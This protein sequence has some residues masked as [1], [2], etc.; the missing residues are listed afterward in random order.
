MK[1]RRSTP[2][3]V[4]LASLC[5]GQA[6]SLRFSAEDIARK[7][8]RAK[9]SFP[10]LGLILAA[11]GLLCQAVTQAQTPATNVVLVPVGSV[12][13]YL[14]NGSDQG[15]AWAQPSFDDSAWLS[16]PAQL[17]YGDGDEATQV[18]FG[19]DPGFKYV[20]TY[21]RHE[22][23]LGDPAPFTGLTV[24]LLRD[25]GGVVYLNGVEVFRSNMPG[26]L[27]DYLTFAA[28]T[29]P[30]TDESRFFASGVDHDL[31]VSG[32][33]VLAVEIHQANRT[34]SDISFD[35]EL[36]ATIPTGPP[37]IVTQPSS[38]EVFVGD[39][40]TFAVTVT[41]DAPLSYQWDLD[42]TDIP[43]AT[44]STLTLTAVTSDAVGTYRV[45]VTNALGSVTSAK[46]DLIV[47]ELTADTF[48]ITGL[49]SKGASAIDA[50]SHTGTPDRGGIAASFNELFV[51]NSAAFGTTYFNLDD[52]SFVN[53]LQGG[54]DS[55]L[56]D[57]KTGRVYV[58]GNG[59]TPLSRNGGTATVLL[60]LDG[61]TGVTNGNRVTLSSPIILPRIIQGVG[62]FSG[63]GRI[64]LHNGTNVFD[65]MLP[66]GQVTDLGAMTMPLHRFSIS[67]ESWAFWGVAEFFGGATWLVYVRDPQ[68]IVRT[69]VPDGF[70]ETVTNFANLGNMFSFTVSLLQD[71]WYFEHDGVS[72]FGTGA[73]TVGYADATFAYLQEPQAPQIVRQPQ[74]LAVPA[75]NTA[76]FSVKV[77]GSSPLSYQWQF[78]GTNI[79]GATGARLTLAVVT[80]NQ[81]GS[82]RVAVSN[83]L[84]SVTSSN[85]TLEVTP[86][87]PCEFSPTLRASVTFQDMLD[88]TTMTIAFDGTNYWS[89]S[90]GGSFG[91]R[92][93]RY[94]SA[95]SLLGT[96]SPGLDLRSI[97]TDA[98][99]TLFA[100]AYAD[101]RIFRQSSPGNFVPVVTLNGGLLDDQSDVV[102][103][104]DGTEFVAMAGG[105]VSRWNR[106]GVFLGS[107]TLSGFGQQGNEAA[108]PQGRGIAIADNS[109][110][111]YSGSGVLSVWDLTGHRTHQ[112]T[113]QSAGTS[114][115]SDY[116]FSFCNGRVFVV[117]Y[118][119]STWRGYDLCINTPPTI[120][121]QPENQAVLA[122]FDV[123]LS[124][125]VSGRSPLLYQWLF[126]GEPIPGA[127]NAALVLN[128]VTTN[129]AG[130]YSFVV[131]N[132][133]GW[134]ASSNALLTVIVSSA[135]TFRIVSLSTNGA[136]VVDANPL[137]GDDRGGIA[138]SSQQVFYSGD[139]STVRFDVADMSGATALGRVYDGLVSELGTETVYSLANGTNL[140]F[141]GSG[142]VNALVELD[143]LTG[144]PTTR[145]IPLSRSIDLQNRSS[146]VG[147]FAGLGRIVLH[148]SARV[149]D[150][151]LPSGIVVDLG[152]MPV[153]NHQYSENWAYWGVAEYTNGSIWLVYVRDSQTIVRTRV[154]DGLTSTVATFNFLSDMASIT[155]SLSL[156]RWY[157]HH[158]GGSQFG[159]FDEAFGFADATLV[160]S[161]PPSAP[162]IIRQPTDQTVATR[163][164]VELKVG[165]RGTALQYQWRFGDTNLLNATNATLRLVNVTTNQSGIYSVVV[166]N[167]LGSV[168]SSNA[169][170]TVVPLVG[171]TF[172]ITALTTN[173]V[174]VMDDYAVAGDDRGGIAVSSQEVF[175]SGDFSTARFD[176]ADLSGGVA[177]GRTYD[178]L[179]SELGSEKVYS[180]GDGTNLISS[181]GGLVAELVELDDVTGEPTGNAIALSHPI[182][183]RNRYGQVGIFAG[184]GRIV[185][186]DGSHA[187]QIA[188][189]SGVVLDLGPMAAFPHQY[190]E[191][192]AYWGVAE[193]VTGSIW[194]VYVRDYQTIVRTRVPDGFTGNFTAFNNLGDMSSITVS[195]PFNR[196]YFHHQYQSQFSTLYGTIGFA[197]AVFAS[198]APPIAPSI[199]RQPQDLTLAARST[200]EFKVVIRGTGLRYQWRFDGVPIP[201]GI[202]STL[203]LPN[204]T[205]NQSGFYSVVVSNTLGVVISSNA[206]LTVVPLEGDTF[207]IASLS[208]NNAVVVDDS[209]LVGYDRG[210]IAASAEQVFFSGGSATAKFDLTDLSG[211]TTLG[212]IYD[213]MVSELGSERLY[214]LGNGTNLI[215]NPGGTVTTLLELDGLS[216]RLTGS[217]ISLSR[218]IEL[219]NRG[220]QV[221]IF[222]G[223]GRIVVHDGGRAW[224]IAVPSGQVLDLGPMSAPIHQYS[225][226]WAY[227]GVAEFTNSALWLVYVRDSQSIVRTRV[228]DGLT[229]PVRTFDSLSDMACITVSL[230]FN[231]WY[232][233]HQYQSQF[234]SFYLTMGFADATFVS[235]LPPLA[236]EIVR[237]PLNE[238][239]AAGATVDFKVVAR[240][241]G[242]RYQWL[243]EG[244]ALPG[245]TNSTLTLRNVTANQAGN[246]SVVVSNLLAS[247]TSANAALSVVTV[248]GNTFQITRLSTNGV[249]TVEQGYLTGDDRGGL[250]AS[251]QELFYSGDLSSARFDLADL[252]GASALGRIHD[253]L[254]SD[255]GSQ[256]IYELGNGTNLIDYRGGTVTT[257][258]ELDEVTGEPTGSGVLLSRPI[259]LHPVPAQIGIFCGVGRIVLHDGTRVWSIELPSGLV[260]NLGTMPPPANHQYSENWAYWGI[261]EFFNGA[262]HLVYV[263]DS[264]VIARTRV[265]DGLTTSLATFEYLGDMASITV[266]LP[267]NR[268][269]FHSQYPPS[270]VQFYE[271]V[272]YADAA[273]AVNL[274][275][276][277]PTIVKQPEDQMVASSG[278]V[279]FKAWAKGTR[280]LQYQWFLD[281]SPLVGV[282][283]AT[284]SLTGVNSNRA[285]H[286]TFVVTNVYGAATSAP[287]LLRVVPPVT[288]AVFDDPNFVNTTS[289]DMY[290]TSDNLQAS[291]RRLGHTVTTFTSIATAANTQSVLLFPSFPYGDLVA[292]L[293]DTTRAALQNFVATGGLLIISSGDP[294]RTTS[295]LNTVF[296][297]TIQGAYPYQ[298]ASARTPLAAGTAFGD[299]PPLLPLNYNASELLASTLPPG[300]RSLY[301][302][303]DPYATTRTR[304]ALIRHGNGKIVFL[305][306]DWTDAFP[307]WRLDNGWLK[308]LASAVEESRPSEAEAPTI[309]SQPASQTLLE[310]L[311]LTF[312]V[313][314][315]GYPL[316]YQ[317][318]FNGTPLAGETNWFLT[319]RPARVDQTGNYA[320]VISNALGVVTS[321]VAVAT[322]R[323]TRG[324][325]A[326]FTDGNPSVTDPEAPILQAGFTP[327]RI[328]DI[329]QFDFARAQLLMLNEAIDYV[330]TVELRR[331]LPELRDWV[332]NGG[333]LIVHDRSVSMGIPQ[334]NA[335]LLGLTRTLLQKEYG[336]DIN[337]IPPG[338]TLVTRGPHGMIG[339]GSLD[340]AGSSY[341]GFA[342]RDTIP[343]GALPILRT[344]LSATQVVAFAYGLGSGS[345]YY[346]ALP[347]DYLLMRGDLL[348][349][350]FRRTYA[351]NVIEFVDAYAGSGQPII[352]DEPQS[353]SRF[354]GSRVVFR[355][356][357][358]G[359]APLRYQW[360]FNGEAITDATN[361]ALV[362]P[363]AT[364]NNIGT[365]T[366]HIA[367]AFGSVTSRPATLI[368]IEAST[369]KI[370]S[371][372]ANGSRVIDHDALTGDDRGSIAVSSNQVF[373]TGDY[374]TARFSAADLTAATGLGRQYDAMVSNL[375][376]ERVYSLADGTNVNPGGGVV[377]ALIEING[378]TGDLTTNRIELSEP[379]VVPYGTGIFAGYDCIALHNGSSVYR[380]EIPS[381]TVINLG[382]MIMPN[383]YGCDN[384]AYWGVT[385]FFNGDVYLVYIQDS[386][387]IA[388]VR[389]PDGETSVVARF[390]YLS[391]MC[392][393][394]MSLSRNRWYFHHEGSSQFGGNSETLGY[395]N[396]AWDHPP[397]IAN[398]TNTVMN[399]DAVIGPINFSI[400]DAETSFSNLVVTARSSN[401][402]LLPDERI[403]LS[404]TAMVRSMRLAP[405]TNEN[406][407]VLVTITVTDLL[408]QV[409]NRTFQ[410][411]V[412]AVNDP[413]SFTAGADQ[414]VFE[415]AGVQSISNWATALSAGPTNESVQNFSFEVSN[416][417]PSL[418]AVPPSISPEGRLTYTPAP[419]ANGSAQVSVQLLDDGGTAD[420]GTNAS[421]VQTFTI[422]VVSVNDPPFFTK[423]SDYVGLEDSGP[424]VLNGWVQSATAGPADEAGQQLAFLV[425]NDNPA[426]FAVAPAISAAGD[427]T[428][429]PA[430][431][432]NGVAIVT[433][434][435]MDNGGS[436][437]GGNDTSAPQTFSITIQP[438]NDR[439]VANSQSVTLAEDTT[440][441]IILSGSDIENAPLSYT[442]LTQPA[443]GT[444]SGSG[445]LLTYRPVTNYA[446]PDSFTFKVNDEA[447]DSLEATVSITVTPV[448]DPPVA[449]S[450]S[451]TN[452]EDTSIIVTLSGSDVENDP[453][454][455]F[456]TM[457]AHGTLSGTDPNLVYHPASNYFGADSFRFRVLAGGQYSEF[458]TVEILILP[459]NDAPNFV[460]GPDVTVAEDSGPRTLANWA[461]N[462]SPGPTNEADQSIDFVVSHNNP[463]LFSV[464]PAISPGGTLTFTPA[465]NAHGSALVTVM[466]HDNGG[467]AN[468]GQNTSAAQSFTITVSSLNDAPVAE[469][470]SVQVDEDTSKAITL[471]GSD[472][473]GD[474]LTFTIVSLPAHGTLS[475]TGPNRTYTPA[476]DY[477]GPDSF[478]FKVNDGQADSAPATVS[479][480]VSGVNDAPVAFIT[481]SPL[482]Y[483]NTGATGVV[484]SANG[485]DA[486]VVLDGSQS[487]DP[488]GSPL[489]YW[490]FESGALTPFATGVTVSNRFEVGEHTVL[491]EVS[492]GQKSS[493]QS[494]QVEI[495]SLSMAV[496]ELV[497][498][499]NA[500]TVA[501]QRKRAL[502]AT[503]KACS[504]SLE[505]G[506]LIS[507]R[508]QLAAFQHKVTA[509]IQPT[510]PASAAELMRLSQLVLSALPA[511]R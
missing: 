190:S 191:N 370:F 299:D 149:W 7:N 27:I 460:K 333:K 357:V 311:D 207:R 491:L 110:L 429:T 128:N 398:I 455:Y 472:V 89:S 444:L 505:R 39:T 306:W 246:Y 419:N 384:W 52:L 381:G 77:R 200:A 347:L 235:S 437:N 183:L 216:G 297:F 32:R 157:F 105:T 443:H 428:F 243:L 106:T 68:S 312:T 497:G 445:A 81:A 119:H 280:P 140:I 373:Y 454:S 50:S 116:S 326:Y 402:A 342:L 274:P 449:Q 489:S 446:G 456:P 175:Y 1:P 278:T 324:V 277:A 123:T 414:A 272:G 360:H 239:A 361:A 180:L 53:N 213:G 480:T 55:L 234:S 43:G 345:V 337:V 479:I 498:T 90:G 293:D 152:P 232:F 438:V 198:S 6:Q 120:A 211:G 379:I 97:F 420:G 122:G 494:V 364:T 466:L 129:Q 450:L 64:A 331:R 212:T 352:L 349:Q 415:D 426:L 251:S 382:Q 314:A 374:Q 330:P 442:L 78:N 459:V 335:L 291:L 309:L 392:C 189:P 468:G 34:S 76:E 481:V 24:R 142:V 115:D 83:A 223:V 375:R 241:T 187:W 249:R 75:G 130:S 482:V 33:N 400:L 423:G 358:T 340:N 353:Q 338:T 315:N 31:L 396:A 164:T 339:D 487:Y 80:T 114:S 488:E 421:A 96:F 310:G 350:T 144:E 327:L 214:H 3:R 107:V 203:K 138:A 371:L 307:R 37:M 192:W 72:E 174:S 126:N 282:T 104:S 266:S 401:Q 508:N 256:K 404:G 416:D 237:Q 40:V 92:L 210:G 430:P 196:W 112:I 279:V 60:E 61:A 412:N 248:S 9:R 82:Y 343:V 511:S 145:T 300:A 245:A 388:R 13:K 365:Y 79:P 169:L 319:L 320:V 408:G 98:S 10:I 162:T 170:L 113:L 184:L 406:G 168:T 156:N 99:G 222:A 54:Y 436:A 204:L 332:E 477:N 502:E 247:V 354:R 493:R 271:T 261:A 150:I 462:I 317:W 133:L 51:L 15:T 503:L 259:D 167:P 228:P 260:V 69:R 367:N 173:G 484:I 159:S 405:A 268:W 147:I 45:T 166:N 296:G 194:L 229:S 74:S 457:P 242:L 118:A 84:G 220:S 318:Q 409:T 471:T 20:T 322:I 134:A 155:V 470:Q 12:W 316:N 369:F 65:I 233:H 93:A 178:A 262:V 25:D 23:T 265:P 351:P 298:S 56:S 102:L 378:N 217:S 447:M 276:A 486:L 227:W 188:M 17:G 258:V 411:T 476:P 469:S 433:V 117:D 283:T 19:P 202:S 284:L 73:L 148:D 236:P 231:R 377:N 49:G 395:A 407:T 206:L 161:L 186:H 62:M 425:S 257:L 137:A 301:E 22:F 255:L 16:G 302:Y 59:N 244:I 507:A 165:A 67:S 127:T 448:D 376:T 356:A 163:S 452:L 154:P 313:I 63:Y 475:G 47:D 440:A 397:R 171:D 329:T 368:I 270:F 26:G 85:A 410:L 304:V 181:P 218:P 286:Y 386:Q 504:A 197:D 344:G 14:D 153:F 38:R 209:S 176:L 141:A 221:G 303:T 172:R 295:F 292:S 432:A 179:V 87:V 403:A 458:A 18:G 323:P 195:L 380:I 5:Q 66:S 146:Q 21:F 177:L 193:F 328:T 70:T 86:V 224:Q 57:L 36:L 285:G 252:S 124:A 132:V 185:I 509:Q 264:Q 389:V 478:T 28:T 240:G 294:Y 496:D 281:G 393:F 334:P 100:R 125:F 143:G 103:N 238:S 230:P 399:E 483:L 71:R 29:I 46:A 275:P 250:A 289:G 253:G 160:S 372:S 109:W 366:L 363:G 267:L 226:T 383:H 42:G 101:R 346:A 490:W 44:N 441:T 108:Y 321:E 58:P 387:T 485:L 390:S 427:L 182:D 305:G 336:N 121:S 434:R 464:A 225:D 424:V 453:L 208:T 290:A 48:K 439:P 341:H 269:Y 41:G 413:P 492:D 510:D 308:I 273:F 461:T 288:V 362:L 500:S 355:A 215:A 219:I 205:T 131:T 506:N 359:A 94:S 11:M 199:V 435:L 348:G 394:S 325:A 151:E 91:L 95:G 4:L 8:P 417:N 135:D 88:P 463:G 139:S 391:D 35:L 158:E 111:T 2:R 385:E 254:V 136:V 501:R 451:V 431:N 474:P 465:L 473:E 499:L 418:F 30:N 422:H 201:G 287:A 495:I 263:R 467:T